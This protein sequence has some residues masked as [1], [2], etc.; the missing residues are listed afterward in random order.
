MVVFLYILNIRKQDLSLYVFIFQTKFRAEISE[1][2][3]RT[4][5]EVNHLPFLS[6]S[7]SAGQKLFVSKF[8]S[9]LG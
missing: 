9:Y 2:I 1:R 3:L 8:L 5:V 6:E 7:C 4:F